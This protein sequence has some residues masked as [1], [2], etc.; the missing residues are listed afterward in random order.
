[1]L[2]AGTLTTAS[3][4]EHLIY[5]MVDNP[6]VLQRLQEEPH[7]VMTSVDDVS[8]VPLATL[9][10]LPYLTAVIKQCIRLVY[11]NSDPQFRVNPNGTLTYDNQTTGRSWLVPPKTS[12]GMTSVM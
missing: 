10:S 5:W 8:K 6:D 4:L 1:L 3:I 9:E 12:V 11:G 2:M 7:S